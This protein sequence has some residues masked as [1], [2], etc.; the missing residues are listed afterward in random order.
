MSIQPVSASQTLWQ[1]LKTDFQKLNQALTAAQSSQGTG[2]TDPVTISQAALQKAAAAFQSDISSVLNSAGNSSSTTSGAG[3]NSGTTPL[4]TLNQDLTNL[5]SAIQSGKQDQ[6]KAAE[7]TLGSDL[8]VILKG[9]HHHHHHHGAQSA[10][11]LSSTGSGSSIAYS[12]G[13]TNAAT[14]TV[15]SS[16]A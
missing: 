4:Q 1:T 9:H 8:S 15:L 16:Q 10:A 3:S 2:N 12:T 7:V 6:I 13:A 14:G 11:S 5:Q